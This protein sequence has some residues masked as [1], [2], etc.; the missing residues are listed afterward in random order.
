MGRPV[1]R[2]KGMSRRAVELKMLEVVQK[3][4]NR[5]LTEAVPFPILKFCDRWLEDDFGVQFVVDDTLAG[6][7]GRLRGNMVYVA[8]EVYDGADAGDGRDRFTLAHEAVHV[9]L[10]ASQL[11][12]IDDRRGTPVLYRAHEI[13]AYENPEWQAN[14]GAAALL[15][16]APAVRLL[17]RRQAFPELLRLPPIVARHLGV[18]LKAAEIRVDQ[19]NKAG[20][21]A[22]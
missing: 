20:E 2:V 9:M 17:Y 18:S 11:K 5:T 19:L 6:A 22:L 1:P 16:P 7:E 10:H 12:A 13:P 14:V 21:L 3:Y 8:S 4:H 15:M